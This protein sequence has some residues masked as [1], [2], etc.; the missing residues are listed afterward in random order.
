MRGGTT[1]ERINTSKYLEG[2]RWRIKEKGEMEGWG[3][4]LFFL[5]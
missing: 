3:S 5:L 4:R 2:G 1:H